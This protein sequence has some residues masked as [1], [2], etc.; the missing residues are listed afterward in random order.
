M[1]APADLVVNKGQMTTKVR[2]QWLPS[3]TATSINSSWK[4]VMIGLCPSTLRGVVIVGLGNYALAEFSLTMH[5]IFVL[6]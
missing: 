5:Y 1:A 2:M 4:V 6:F 3:L